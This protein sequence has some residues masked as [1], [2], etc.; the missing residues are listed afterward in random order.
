MTS[1]ARKTLRVGTREGE[2]EDESGKKDRV[3]TRE[4]GTEGGKE[5]REGGRAQAV[6]D[7]G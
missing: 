5:K 3:G 7:A 2:S 6:W 4:G 1:Q